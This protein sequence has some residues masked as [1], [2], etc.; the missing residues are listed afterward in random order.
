MEELSKFINKKVLKLSNILINICKWA[1]LRFLA[2]NSKWQPFVRTIQGIIKIQQKRKK[3]LFKIRLK[4]I[5]FPHFS[6]LH[7]HKLS[8]TYLVSLLIDFPHV[9]T[10]WERRN[11]YLMSVIINIIY[12]VHIP[13]YTIENT[14]FS[15]ACHTFDTKSDRA[16]CG[17]GISCKGRNQSL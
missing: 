2:F 11:I 10:W 13:T 1:L 15:L 7:F 6:S 3:C 8:T 16:W 14:D 4:T 17:I 12:S 9:C 5:F